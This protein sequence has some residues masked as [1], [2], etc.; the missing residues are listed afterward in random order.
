MLHRM[1]G[2]TAF[3]ISAFMNWSIWGLAMPAHAAK[4]VPLPVHL[5]HSSFA[6]GH[7]G[8]AD[9]ITLENST[10]VG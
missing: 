4:S 10:P 8:C 9:P 3:Q 7:F 6:I 1:I 5:R 2:G